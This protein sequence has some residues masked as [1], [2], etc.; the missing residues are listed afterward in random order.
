MHAGGAWDGKVCRTKR[1][2][3]SYAARERRLSSVQDFARPKAL[4]STSTAHVLSPDPQ[5][6]STNQSRWPVTAEEATWQGTIPPSKRLKTLDDSST[7]DSGQGNPS[8]GNSCLY[9]P[10]VCAE[11]TWKYGSDGNDFVVEKEEGDEDLQDSS[12]LNLEER[13]KRKDR[14][15]A[16]KS[17]VRIFCCTPSKRRPVVQTP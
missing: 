17:Q 10:E 8:S 9:F 4:R 11:L 1:V 2:V 12:D 15:R 5:A 13:Q 14:R 6:L 16:F 3:N 7:T